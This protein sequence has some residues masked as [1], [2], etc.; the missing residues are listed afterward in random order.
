MELKVLLETSAGIRQSFDGDLENE[1][2]ASQFAKGVKFN[3]DGVTY[4]VV[5]V[6]VDTSAWCVYIVIKS[7][8]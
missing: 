2:D 8:Y 3:C 1:A 5:A 7:L 4:V 6:A